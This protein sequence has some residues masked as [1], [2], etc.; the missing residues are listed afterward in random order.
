MF[1]LMFPLPDQADM[2]QTLRPK[3]P[4]LKTF[5]EAAAAVDDLL[6]SQSNGEIARSHKRIVLISSQVEAT[7]QRR[8][9][10]VT[11]KANELSLSLKQKKRKMSA[12][13]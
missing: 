11:R 7:N 2:G 1:F 9:M 13:L 8:K 12:S 6:A 3:V 5:S 4:H 10:E